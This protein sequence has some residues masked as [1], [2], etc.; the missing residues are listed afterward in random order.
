M[1]IKDEI[2]FRNKIRLKN[3]K[4]AKLKQLQCQLDIAIKNQEPATNIKNL[5]EAIG[6]TQS[7]LE[8]L[9]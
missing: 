3:I 8:K 9:T 5:K 7:E 1:S 4:R 6:E 2:A